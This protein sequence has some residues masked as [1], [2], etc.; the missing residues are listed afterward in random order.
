M[1]NVLFIYLWKSNY[2]VILSSQCLAVVPL[3]LSP[4]HQASET[5][6]SLTES[7]NVNL[8]CFMRR[9]EKVKKRLTTK[10][11]KSRRKLRCNKTSDHLK[12]M[13]ATLM[14]FSAVF[15]P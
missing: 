11:G 14:A 8:A 9:R 5:R 10:L 13:L 3:N 12:K 1:V 4:I 6:S 7:Q 15:L 2:F